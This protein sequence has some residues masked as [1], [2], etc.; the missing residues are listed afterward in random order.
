MANIV[1]HSVSRITKS[2]GFGLAVFLSLGIGIG[3][4]SAVLGLLNAVFFAPLPYRDAGQ[5]I[6]IMGR[7][8]YRQYARWRDALG[9]FAEFLPYRYTKSDVV[10][11]NE[12]FRGLNGCVL[13]LETLS[14]LGV[15]PLM[16]IYPNGK[17]S[18]AVVVSYRAWMQVF[19][20]NP[21][22]IGGSLV[23]SGK[24]YAVTA[25]MP[26]GFSFPPAAGSGSDF[27]LEG[28]HGFASNEDFQDLDLVMRLKGGA[29]VTSIRPALDGLLIR[30]GEAGPPGRVNIRRLSRYPDDT[31]KTGLGIAQAAAFVLLLLSCVSVAGL[32]LVRA[33]RDRP[34]ISIRLALGASRGRIARDLA[35]ECLLMIAGVCVSSFFVAWALV[36]NM[37]YLLPPSLHDITSIIDWRIAAASLGL[38]VLCIGC[39]GFYPTYR[40]SALDSADLLRR[41]LERSGGGLIG[42]PFSSSL[43]RLIAIQTAVTLALLI[44]S[45]LLIETLRHLWAVPIGFQPAHLMAFMADF[46]EAKYASDEQRLALDARVRSELQA[47]PEVDHVGGINGLPFWGYSST[48]ISVR[49]PDAPAVEVRCGFVTP[50]FFT[51][52]KIGLLRGQL[53]DR[54]GEH[55]AIV[56]ASMAAM[57][58]PAEEPIGQII[59]RQSE[60]S[61]VS[62]EIVAVVGDIRQQGFT[63][64][65]QPTVYFDDPYSGSTYVVRTSADLLS[66]EKS[67]LEALSR[68]DPEIVSFDF[69]S[70]DRVLARSIATQRWAANLLSF[71]GAIAFVAASIGMYAFV[72]YTIRRR[73]REIGIRLAVGARSK[74]V[75]LLIMYRTLWPVAA[76]A[77]VGIVAAVAGSHFVRSLLFGVAADD[78]VVFVVC[79][80]IVIFTAATATGVAFVRASVLNPLDA[81]R[82]P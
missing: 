70:M 51:T 5:L 49:E 59:W 38:A 73:A 65:P 30:G 23:V 16:G 25:I 71:L 40:R 37:V 35:V 15:A 17:G 41:G 33:E 14:T 24:Q 47:L 7:Q 1:A 12:R 39:F 52:M 22:A 29:T 36:R 18:E 66:F 19:G 68:S 77:G 6:E 81:L 3:T 82:Q 20:G 72:A 74:D 2:P 28:G 67:A 58:W 69:T 44:G 75:V 63:A 76:G 13:P 34:A 56:S 46:P 61:K 9:Q 57:F 27:W 53:P 42:S 48:Q 8:S 11:G 64:A 10:V 45:G 26:N 4:S 55:K 80:L 78:L 31:L 50:G 62:Y 32:Y 43:G 54:A 60:R 21:A 79:T